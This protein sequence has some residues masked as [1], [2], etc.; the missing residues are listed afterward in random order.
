[1]HRFKVKG[2]RGFRGLG[3]SGYYY[4]CYYYY[5]YCYCYFFF[6]RSGVR[7]PLCVP[8]AAN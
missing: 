3:F 8:T 2:F 5:Y 6:P 1:M 4:Y 7:E